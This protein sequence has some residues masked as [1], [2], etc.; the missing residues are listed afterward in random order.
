[1]GGLIG[2]ILNN[3]NIEESIE[4]GSAAAA[5]VVKKVGCS[6]AMPN[7]DEIKKFMKSNQIN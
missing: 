6:P 4:I 3:Y 5:I 7:F 2:S 1:M